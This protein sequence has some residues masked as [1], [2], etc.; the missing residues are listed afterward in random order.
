MAKVVI[1]NDKTKTDNNELRDCVIVVEDDHVFSPKE[2]D[3]FEIVTV[4]G[5]K[6][7]VEAARKAAEPKHQT[8]WSL[9][10]QDWSE[11]PPEEIE[12]WNDGKDWWKIDKHI[13]HKTR[14]SKTDN[15]FKHNFE[16]HV[17][18]KTLKVKVS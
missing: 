9:G 10:V 11:T 16:R 8:L 6:A 18:N 17:E 12:A 15:C 2:I 5:T 14:W 13:V 1:I 7:E 4:S 3:I